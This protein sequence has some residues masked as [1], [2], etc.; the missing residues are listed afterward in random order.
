MVQEERRLR[1]DSSPMALLMEKMDAALY[2]ATP[3][4]APVIGFPA[5]VAGL[6]MQDA[7]DFYRRFYTPENAIVVIVGDV[8]P[9]RAFALA[10][11]IYGKVP[12]GWGSA[13]GRAA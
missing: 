5:D 12:R 3:Y 9:D 7:L 2:G 11:E 10:R 8:T 6:T 13:T 1:T 4:G